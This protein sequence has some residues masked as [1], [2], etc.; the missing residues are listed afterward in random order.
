M[1]NFYMHKKIANL[2]KE[3]IHPPQITKTVN[4]INNS[5]PKNI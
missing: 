2:K 5:T 1:R 4:Y 3:K